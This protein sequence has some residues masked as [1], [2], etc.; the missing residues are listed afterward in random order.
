MLRPLIPSVA[1]L[2]VI[3]AA[4]AMPQSPSGPFVGF[5]AGSYHTLALRSDGSILA[6]GSNSHGQ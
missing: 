5:A 2:L 3:P 1:T 4:W 6:Q